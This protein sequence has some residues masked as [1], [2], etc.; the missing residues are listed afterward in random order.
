MARYD[1]DLHENPFFNTL[2]TKYNI[3]FS[4]AAEKKWMVSRLPCQLP[5]ASAGT[6]FQEKGAGRVAE[7][8]GF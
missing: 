6:T 2:V 4:E 1:E 5:S 7:Y 8:K 3:M